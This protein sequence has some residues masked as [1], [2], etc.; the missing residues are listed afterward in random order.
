MHTEVQVA[1]ISGITTLIVGII[2]ACAAYIGSIK[3]AKTQI[4]HE[5]ALLEK[6]E[7]E[8]RAFAESAI[9]QFIMR[10]VHCNFNNI[11]N[12]KN[13][14]VKLEEKVTNSFYHNKEF[15]YKKFERYKNYLIKSNTELVKRIFQ[16]YDVFKLL[17]AN[18]DFKLFTQKEYEYINN[19]VKL[20]IQ[21]DREKLY[22]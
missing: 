6:K 8:Q 3:G 12:D 14:M 11:I 18:N 22:F 2:S 20:Y 21:C 7:A 5:K 10:E 13:M 17:E 19:T 9:Q 15:I 4:E 16:Y 1:I